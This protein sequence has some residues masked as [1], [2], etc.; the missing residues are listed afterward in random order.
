MIKEK[1]DKGEIKI[2]YIPTGRM[3]ADGLT[4]PLQG[5]LGRAI[6][7]R[8]MEGPRQPASCDGR[9]GCVG[10]YVRAEPQKSGT[11]KHFDQRKFLPRNSPTGKPRN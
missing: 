4:K 5:E 6:A 10:P 7:K 8:L 3:L 11:E 1:V 2:E 9:Q